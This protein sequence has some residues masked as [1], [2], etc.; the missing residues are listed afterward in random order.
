MEDKNLPCLIIQYSKD[1]KKIIGLELTTTYNYWEK[2][3]FIKMN[4]Q[5]L[6][7]CKNKRTNYKDFTEW[8]SFIEMYIIAEDLYNPY[9][10]IESTIFYPGY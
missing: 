9:K 5:Q 7:P 8:D 3:A 2:E 6:F 10:K 4:E 1:G